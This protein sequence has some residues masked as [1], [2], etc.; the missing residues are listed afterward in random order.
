M[1]GIDTN[2][3]VRYITQD[4][5]EASAATKFL[6]K[7]CSSEK[8]G[9]ICHIVLCELVWVLKGAY[10]YDKEAV[11]AI[12]NQLLA[13][14]ELELEDSLSVW[15]ALQT[16]S[17]GNA[18]FSDYLIGYVCDENEVDSVYTLDKKAAKSELFTLLKT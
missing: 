7:Q 18:D 1:L 14:S 13:T 10:K 12:L 9:F 3:L 17:T 2:I 15:R 6:E 5:R 8:P 4:G 11:I 16:Y